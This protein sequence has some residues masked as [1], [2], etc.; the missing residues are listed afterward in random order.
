MGKNKLGKRGNDSP[1]M[2]EST[3]KGRHDVKERTTGAR[4]KDIKR[5]RE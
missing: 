4:R 5:R 3:W 2:K 1:T